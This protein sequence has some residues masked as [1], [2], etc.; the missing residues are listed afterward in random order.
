VILHMVSNVQQ[1]TIKP[2]IHHD[3][4]PGALVQTEFLVEPADQAVAFLYAAS[5]AF[6]ISGAVLPLSG[7]LERSN[8]R[9]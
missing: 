7:S 5:T 9:L 6:Q 1:A 3:V 8:W 4:A 2:L